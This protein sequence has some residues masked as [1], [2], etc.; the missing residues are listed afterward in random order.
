[1]APLVSR[2]GLTSGSHRQAY[3]DRIGMIEVYV[4]RLFVPRT[5]NKG[6]PFPRR[7][8]RQTEWALLTKFDGLTIWGEV[9]GQWISPSGRA[10]LDT[11]QVYEVAHAGRERAWWEKFKQELKEQFAQEEIWIL[12]SSTG[13]RVL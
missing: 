9:Q 13:W 12:Q 2:H 5:N 4:T 6:L 11:H 10:H 7:W 3:G 1:M 8:V